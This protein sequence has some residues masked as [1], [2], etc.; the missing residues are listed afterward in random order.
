MTIRFLV[1]VDDGFRTHGTWVRNSGAACTSASLLI[2]LGLLGVPDLPSLREASR[3]FGATADFGAPGL[4]DYLSFPGRRAP[5]D[6]RVERLAAARGHPVSSRTGCVLPTL[7]LRA[8]SS[9]GEVLV[10]HLLYGQE[11]PGVYGC[12]GFRPLDRRTWATGGHS[13]VVLETGRR[14]KVLD[15]NHE[16]IQEWPRPGIA[17]T[18]TRLRLAPA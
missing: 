9:G 6:V 12:W 11:R 2:G 7:P 16:E 1:A 5:L 3:L 15:P 13:V 17:L 8:P 10:A 18:T 14:W 4:L